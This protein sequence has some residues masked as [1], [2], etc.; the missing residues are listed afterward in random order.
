MCGDGLADA[1]QLGR[2]IK[3]RKLREG[4]MEVLGFFV[5]ILLVQSLQV[6]EKRP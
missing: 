5:S 6:R 4:K 2:R 1:Q 3:I